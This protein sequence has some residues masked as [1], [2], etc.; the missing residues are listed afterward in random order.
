MRFLKKVKKLE[1]EQFTTDLINDHRK[2]RE[3]FE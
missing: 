2:Q 1:D 3:C